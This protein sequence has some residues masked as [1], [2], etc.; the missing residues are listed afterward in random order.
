[1]EAEAEERAK[2]QMKQ[3]AELQAYLPYVFLGDPSR[4]DRLKSP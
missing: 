2:E 3:W 1:M 4:Y